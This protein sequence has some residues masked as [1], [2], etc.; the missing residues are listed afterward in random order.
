MDSIDITDST[1]SLDVPDINQVFGSSDLVGGSKSDYTMYIYIGVAILV[2]LIG[3]LI[4]KFYQNKKTQQSENNID[5]P[6]G[7]CTIR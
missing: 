4:Y 1:F 2:A 6:G 3:I 5:C 7:F